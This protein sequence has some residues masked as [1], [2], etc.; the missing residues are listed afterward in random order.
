M[1]FSTAVCPFVCVA[2]PAYS[3]CLC[4]KS[5]LRFTLALGV[6][7]THCTQLRALQQAGAYGSN[8]G[9]SGSVNGTNS[10]SAD[11]DVSSDVTTT[12]TGTAAAAAND[13]DETAAAAAAVAASDCASVTSEAATSTTDFNAK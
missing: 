12:A 8:T 5:L 7:A 1:L 11:A 13:R 10:S 3:M 4:N 2:D 6:V 9:N